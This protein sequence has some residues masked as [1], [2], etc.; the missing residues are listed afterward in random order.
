M[1][2]LALGPRRPDLPLTPLAPRSVMA[3]ARYHSAVVRRSVL[4]ALVCVIFACARAGEA[5][6]K[7]QADADRGGAPPI[8]SSIALTDR[9]PAAEREPA[10][11]APAPSEASVSVPDLTRA[12]QSTAPRGRQLIRLGRLKMSDP[13]SNAERVVA[14]ARGALASCVVSKD[15]VASG[16]AVIVLSV[17]RSGRVTRATVAPGATLPDAAVLCMQ[18]VLARAAFD[19]HDVDGTLEL[20][21]SVMPAAP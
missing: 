6:P 16:D 10:A 11:T 15:A 2:L 20:P 19:R 9:V 13:V 4:S 3:R 5:P 17:A 14:M 7:P 21:V 18:R 12:A 1:A 8:A